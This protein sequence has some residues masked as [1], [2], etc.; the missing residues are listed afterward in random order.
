M[1]TQE[2]RTRIYESD[3]PEWKKA[4]YDKNKEKIAEQNKERS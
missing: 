3:S 2:A 1:P 4:Y